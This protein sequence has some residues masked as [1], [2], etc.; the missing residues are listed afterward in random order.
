MIYPEYERFKVRFASMQERFADVLLEKERLFTKTQPNAIRYDKDQVQSSIDGNMLE[1]YVI[2]LDEEQIEE[3]LA[4]LRQSLQDWE[5]LINLKEKEL[6]K[7]KVMHDRIYVYKYLEGY[8]IN[9]I[10]KE[11]N[12]SRSQVYRILRQIEKRCNILRQ[13]MCYYLN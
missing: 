13:N 11:L 10:S 3:K 5:I 12:Y 4:K 6:R 9:R 2:S 1:D 8:G 7:S